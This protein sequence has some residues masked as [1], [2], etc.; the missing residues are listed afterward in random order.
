LDFDF[1]MSMDGNTSGRT[2]RSPLIPRAPIRIDRSPP[3]RLTARDL[4]RIAQDRRKCRNELVEST[5]NLN[6]V[7]S[8]VPEAA[9]ESP[10][11]LDESDTI[12]DQSYSISPN[13]YL[14]PDDS[15]DTVA[16]SQTGNREEGQNQSVHWALHNQGWQDR[17]SIESDT[18]SSNPLID[19]SET[20]PAGEGSRGLR[21]SSDRRN[22][23]SRNLMGP[24]S[25]QSFTRDELPTNQLPVERVDERL[26][27][28]PRSKSSTSQNSRNT[29]KVES[30]TEILP[31]F[32]NPRPVPRANPRKRK[33]Q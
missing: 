33:K 4:Q 10:Q 23:A 18:A 13:T 26:V 12:S 31:G 14:S 6:D 19:S 3:R 8:E 9:V 24:I 29:T 11:V 27:L 30:D 2:L 15:S 1:W 7:Q 25:R 20:R 32:E 21:N 16:Y 22:S 28:R 17:L 5:T